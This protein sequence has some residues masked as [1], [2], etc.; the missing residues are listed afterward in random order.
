MM[1]EISKAREEDV[2]S[3]YRYI[4]ELEEMEF[5]YPKFQK[6]YERN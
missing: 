3:I 6:L 5:D 2:T 4:C 1:D